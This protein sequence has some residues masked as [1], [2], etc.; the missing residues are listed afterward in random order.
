MQSEMT[1]ID[2]GAMTFQQEDENI[3]KALNAL[4]KGIVFQEG[5]GKT[6]WDTLLEKQDRINEIL[7]F[8]SA[9]YIVRDNNER[10][11][12]AI[13]MRDKADEVDSEEWMP[14]VKELDLM[15]SWLFVLLRK[16]YKEWEDSGRQPPVKVGRV[17][18]EQKLREYV[19]DFTDEGDFQKKAR[20][21]LSI[22]SNKWHLIR[23]EKDTIFI[24]P[25]ITDVVDAKW[26]DE[27]CRIEEEKE[28]KERE[29]EHLP[30]ETASSGDAL[31]LLL[32]G[33]KDEDDETA[34]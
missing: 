23:C 14:N 22:I 19:K 12:Y 2:N 27:F 33:R 25:V 6:V 16:A 4:Q 20:G 31:E 24:H 28:K 11:A 32:N 1:D 5:I 30:E 26:L 21:K 3:R 9:H 10:Y 7:H 18:I 8:F 15:T 29:G 13:L 17:D 34:V